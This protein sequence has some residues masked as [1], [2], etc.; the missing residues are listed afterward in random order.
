MSITVTMDPGAR[1]CGRRAVRPDLKKC[2]QLLRCSDRYPVFQ[3]IHVVHDD[4]PDGSVRLFI[5][6]IAL[7]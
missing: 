5:V 6:D 3:T 7:L 2:E 4:C 1:A